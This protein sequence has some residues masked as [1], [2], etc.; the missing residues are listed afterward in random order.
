MT[1][2]LTERLNAQSNLKEQHHIDS[3]IAKLNQSHKLETTQKEKQS[4]HTS[5]IQP[6]PTTVTLSHFERTVKKDF[7]KLEE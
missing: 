3:T 1:R 4:L 2:H 6:N 7:T 5:R